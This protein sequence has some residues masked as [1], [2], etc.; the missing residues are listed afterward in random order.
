MREEAE[1]HLSI[2]PPLSIHPKGA[3]TPNGSGLDPR[4]SR[5]F[6]L[7][8]RVR[9]EAANRYQ[10]SFSSVCRVVRFVHFLKRRLRR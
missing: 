2:P 5:T 3:L 8:R 6:A 9:L 7:K 4:R 1:I 10:I